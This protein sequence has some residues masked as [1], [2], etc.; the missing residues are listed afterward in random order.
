MIRTLSCA[1]ATCVDVAVLG[2]SMFSSAPVAVINAR[3]IDVLQFADIAWPFVS[4]QA[5]HVALV[6]AMT[7]HVQAG[8]NELEKMRGQQWHIGTT[9]TQARGVNGEYIEPE[10][11]VFAKAFGLHF[12]T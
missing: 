5:R 7:G 3:S 11:Q 10:K 1:A 8:T 2:R 6:Q 12:R 4:L 9:L